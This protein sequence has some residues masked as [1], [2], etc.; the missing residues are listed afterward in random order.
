MPEEF[1]GDAPFVP[2]SA[3]TGQGIDSLLEQVL[4]QAEVLELKCP[5]RCA[6]QGPGHRS[7]T[8]QGP[9]PGGHGAGAERHAE[10]R[11][12]GAGRQ[13]LRPRAR[14]AGR[15]RQADCHRGRPVD[16]GRD[17]GSVR[18]AAAPA[19]SSWCW[20]TSAGR[21]RSPL[22][23]Q[24]KYRDVKLAKQQAAKLETMFEQHGRRARRRRW[25]SSSRPTCR[26]RRKRWR[27]RLLK[28]ST[29]RGA[30]ADRARCRGRYH[31]ERR[32][33]GACFQGGGHRLQHPRRCRR[34]QAGRRQRRGPAL[35]QHHLRRGGRCEG[36]HE[37]GMLAPEQREEIIGTAEIRNVFV[38]SKI[39]TIAGCM[40]TNGI[41]QARRALPPAARERGDLHR[42]A[43]FAQALQGRRQARSRKASSAA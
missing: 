14:H 22:F 4:L 20:P 43:R 42:R 18:S 11:R 13:H 25:R 5:G 3:K 16:P 33:P 26:A 2:V 36:G 6:G 31:R 35:L 27:S 12:R 40:V 9:R 10:A 39:G 21:A 29:E 1:G 30:R 19:K 8:G 37:S 17:S 15:R 7:Q 28:L 24:G 32:Q 38:A 23:R 41:G 34:A